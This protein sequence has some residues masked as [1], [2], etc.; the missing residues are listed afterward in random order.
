MPGCP[1]AE[2]MDLRI[3][4]IAAKLNTTSRTVFS[5][6]TGKDVP[7]PAPTVASNLDLTGIAA[8]AHYQHRLA[9]AQITTQ[10]SR[11]STVAWDPTGPV[12]SPVALIERGCRPRR[13]AYIA[14]V[15]RW[16]CFLALQS[17]NPGHGIVSDWARCSALGL[18]YTGRGA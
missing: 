3:T 13:T 8:V 12:L 15:V 9:A 2:W 1:R 18:H 14:K 16:T 17:S 10:N 11:S 5:G 4:S 7:L 6:V